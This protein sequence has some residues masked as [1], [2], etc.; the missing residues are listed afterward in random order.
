MENYISDKGLIKKRITVTIR[1][2][3]K[4]QLKRGQNI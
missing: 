2:I 3:F 4:N 1:V